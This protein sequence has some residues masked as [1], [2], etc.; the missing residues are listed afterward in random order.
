MFVA[1]C[2]ILF[3]LLDFSMII[4]RAY[5]ASLKIAGAI[6]VYKHVSLRHSVSSVIWLQWDTAG[7]ERFKTLGCHYYRDAEAIVF[8]YDVTDEVSVL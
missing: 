2:T 5:N 4:S 8:V 3:F 6:S 7:Q 1:R